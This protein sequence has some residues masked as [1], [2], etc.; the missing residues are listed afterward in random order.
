MI[1]ITSEQVGRINALLGGVKNAPQKVIYNV[2]NR[3]T[4]TVVSQSSKYVRQTYKIKHGDLTSNRNINVSRAGPSKLEA[5]ISYGGTLIPLMKF[6]VDPKQPKRKHVTVSVLANGSGQ[7]LL[8]A[9][10]AD[11][12]HGVGVFE[13]ET[14][15]RDSSVQLFGPSAA[16]MVEN[17]EVLEK[18]ESAAMETI[19]KRVEH[20]ISRILNG[21]T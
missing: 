19:N 8:H 11:L 10:V 6:N 7:R 2:L 3:A 17:A 15:A 1:E 20:E 9:Y 4:G 12:G 16:H 21:Y 18:V 5:T 14:A 13:R